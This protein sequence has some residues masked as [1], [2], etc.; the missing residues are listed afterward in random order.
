MDEGELEIISGIK[1]EDVYSARV[2]WE[3]KFVRDTGSFTFKTGAKYRSSNPVWDRTVTVYEMDEE[4]PYAQVVT[5]T[6]RVQMMKPKHYDVHPHLGEALLRSN[7][8]LFE[9]NQNA[10][11]NNS[12]LGDYDA[13]EDTSAGYGM[14]TWRWGRHTLIAGVR[15][16]K[17]E[18]SSQ[19]KDVDLTTRTVSPR[20]IGASYDYW[21][22]GVHLRHEL[23]KNLILRESFNQ[24]YGRPPLAQLTRGRTYAANGNIVD[25]NS[26]LQPAFSDNFEVQLEYYT[27]NSGLYSI[28]VFYKDVVDFTF[29]QVGRFDAVDA[30]GDPILISGGEFQYSRP[31][32]GSTATN[33]GIELIARQR[34]N[35][36]FIPDFLRGFSAAVSATFTET[37]AT[38]PN[39]TDDREL[40]LPGFSDYLFTSSLE[41]ARGRF[42]ARLDYRYREDYVEGLGDNI[43]SDEFY[44]AEEKVDA[45]LGFEIRRG[46]TLFAQASNLTDRPQVSYQGFGPFVEDA[47]ISGRKFT[48]GIDFDF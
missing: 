43:E 33:L 36:G 2:D 16:E 30:D 28:G 35:F 44:A 19:R 13:S 9:L 34:L 41:Y 48:V 5:P 11:L 4:F 3:K 42:F 6:D 24:S 45:E 31:E 12:N 39:R 29:T 47:S 37:E 22:P 8:E 20:N 23:T 15:W 21:L 27:A 17:N 10:T 32:N 38:Y 25:G 40:P 7:P 26:N 46:V 18:W 1:T 14:G